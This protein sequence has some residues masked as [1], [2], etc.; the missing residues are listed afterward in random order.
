[1]GDVDGVLNLFK[2]TPVIAATMKIIIT[3]IER[4]VILLLKI[5]L[6]V[7]CYYSWSNQIANN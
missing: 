7:Y 2:F 4:F 5:F 6:S 1:M 3:I